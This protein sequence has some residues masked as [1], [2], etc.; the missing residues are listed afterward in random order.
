MIPDFTQEDMDVQSSNED[1]DSQSSNEDSDSQ[2]SSEESMDEEIEFINEGAFGCVF[3]PP[4]ECIEDFTATRDHI[5]KVFDKVKHAND[6]IASNRKIQ[7]QIDPNNTFTIKYIGRCIVK[8]IKDK[9]LIKTIEKT[10]IFSDYRDIEKCPQLIYEY[11]G[12]DFKGIRLT[13]LD[14]LASLPAWLAIFNGLA[15]LEKN[16]MVHQDVKPENL[17]YNEKYEKI[18]LIDFGGMQRYD[19]IY[20]QQDWA[21][22]NFNYLYFPPEYKISH[23][24]LYTK[25]KRLT[26]FGVY[27]NFAGAS[28][29]YKMLKK[30]FKYAELLLDYEEHLEKIRLDK[31]PSQ[32]I[33]KYFTSYA[34]RIDMYSMGITLVEI[35]YDNK[36]KLRNTQL[37]IDLKKLIGRLIQPNPELRPTPKSAYKKIYKIYRDFIA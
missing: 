18:N 13:R 33:K 36:I 14:F 17:L 22:N 9:K 16:K 26:T 35:L 27:K 29:I 25:N 19:E 4:L 6:E 32:D 28:G 10:E 15:V 2:S 37:E 23:N 20:E 12:V 30:E 21:R 1:S 7:Q 11:G 24:L 8:E 34:N 3:R 31:K 5:G